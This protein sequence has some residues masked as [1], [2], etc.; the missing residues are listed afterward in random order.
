M[1]LRVLLVAGEPSGDLHGAALVRA[2]RARVPDVEIA[3]IGGPQLRAEGMRVLVDTEH[4]ATMGFTETFGT[5]GRLLA[6][7]RRLVRFLDEERPALVVLIDYPEFNLRL[8]KHAKRRGIPV[9]YFVA[10]QV[11]AW[12]KGRIQT[13]AKR[14]DKLAAVF[15]FE[16]AIYNTN[17]RPLAE[18]VGHPLLDVVR[19]TA[20]REAT[21]ARYGLATDRPVLALLPGSRKK[22]VAYLFGPMCAAARQLAAEGWQPIVAL[23]ESLSEADLRAALGGAAVPVPI[24]HAD[25]YNVV[26]AADAAVVASGTATLET[27][28]LGCPM[29]ISY[30]VSPLTFWIARRLVDVEFIGMPNII[31]ERAVLPE[32]L[33]EGVTPAAVAA[34][35]R[36][37]HARRTEITAALADLRVHLGAPGAAARAADMALA[38]VS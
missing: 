16:P 17:G 36:D 18:F 28:L 23:A 15:P 4:V 1:S 6:A 38:L 34:A 9:F 26:A 37:V 5:L 30:K 10:P 21:R 14:V 8:A 12:R 19:P 7:Y 22:E 2:L 11:W 25:T 27:A 24:A 13:I 35:V 20:S 33:Q 3:G 32:L 29:V 31:L